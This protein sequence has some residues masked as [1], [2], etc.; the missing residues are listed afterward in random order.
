MMLADFMTTKLQEK[1][2]LSRDISSRL[3]AEL[4]SVNQD[5]SSDT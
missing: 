2:D 3:C 5:N 4:A 1:A